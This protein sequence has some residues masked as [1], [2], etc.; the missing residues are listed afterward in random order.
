[1][2][3]E[4][5]IGLLVFMVSALSIILF[6]F[7]QKKRSVRTLRPITAINRLRRAIGQTIEDGKLI[8]ISLGKTNLLHDTATSALVGLATLEGVARISIAADCSPIATSGNGAISILSQDTIRAAYRMRNAQERY[9][10]GCGLLSGPTPFSYIAGTIPIIHDE[11]IFTNIMIGNFGPEVALLCDA[12]NYEKAFTL[13]ASESLPAQAVMFAAAQEPLIGE[14]LY[15]IPAYLQTKTVYHA[16]LRAQDLLRW[17]LVIV[18]V[19]GAIIR[20]FEYISGIAII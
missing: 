14:E 9:Y 6:T 10:P 12:A 7:F 2:S 17:I 20:I 1:M 15:A 18:M 13:A 4:N 19:A 3:V 16:S 5:R 8:H 11:N